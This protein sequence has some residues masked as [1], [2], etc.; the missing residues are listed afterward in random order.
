MWEG[1]R[2]L[3][4]LL[5]AGVDLAPSAMLFD[6]DRPPQH[7]QCMISLHPSPEYCFLIE[8][9]A[10]LIEDG[11]ASILEII[12]VGRAGGSCPWYPRAYRAHP[13]R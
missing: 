4:L 5:N 10:D 7:D 3:K 8:P 2:G 9:V 1:Q 12:L 11:H 13:E 6:K